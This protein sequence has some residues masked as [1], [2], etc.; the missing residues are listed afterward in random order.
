[1]LMKRKLLKPYLFVL[2]AVLTSMLSFGQ[3]KIY[4]ANQK[5][6]AE[7]YSVEISNIVG[8]AT[9]IKF[10]LEI[11]NTSSEF[12]LFDASK[13]IFTINGA[14]VTPKDKF[15]II[16]PYKKK[17]KTIV[18]LGSGYNN[19]RDFKFELNGVQ[20]V[21]PTEEK[22]PVSAFT[23][24]PSKN[25]FSTGDF[26]V[27]LKGF[28]KETGATTS[29]FNVQYKGKKIGFVSPSKISVLMPDGKEYANG[30]KT[31]PI[32]LFPGGT[33]SFSANWERMPG[34]SL[35]DMQKVEMNLN[36]TDVFTEAVT[37]DLSAQSFSFSWDE[38]LT[39]EKNK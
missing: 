34:G 6:T 27:E 20:R 3:E 31:D 32:L 39:K 25:D 35:N 14:T 15:I 10:K 8:L 21:V 26:Y 5:Q 7:N 33:D 36:F 1:M 18:A 2:P 4:Y 24:P 22:F 17:S 11:E 16:E 29:K 38:A 19:V 23:F 30:K 12:L 9:E 28:K 13:C 37:V